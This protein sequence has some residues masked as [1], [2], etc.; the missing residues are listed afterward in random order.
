VNDLLLDLQTINLASTEIEVPLFSDEPK[1]PS[2]FRQKPSTG[3]YLEGEVY[4][5]SLA[6]NVE[7]ARAKALAEFY[8]RLCLYNV[9]RDDEPKPWD[10]DAG[11]IDPTL[12]DPVALPKRAAALRQSAYIWLDAVE[13]R[14][15]GKT[16][17]PAQTVIPGFGAEEER[18]LV[19]VGPGGTALGRVG[20]GGAL[21][22]GLFEVLERF[23]FA[24]S[25][26]QER[27][28]KRIVHLPPK[29]QSIEQVMRRYG[30]EP[31]VCPLQTKY[32]IPCVLVAL[33]DYS[34]VAPAVSLA[35]RAASTYAAAIH[36]ALFE[37]LERRRPARIEETSRTEESTAP[38]VYPWES[39]ETLRE[40]EPLLKE[41]EPIEF[42]SLP[43]TPRTS[44]DLLA[45]LATDDLDV[46]SVDLTLPEV[47]AAGFEATKIVIPG[48]GPM[49]S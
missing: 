24:S 16:K 6:P 43:D 5:L 40:M 13:I 21:Q 7:E 2:Y 45:C 41:A 9:S 48:L 4:G 44:E 23:T 20:D 19:G 10:E 42:S 15:G 26:L 49:P 12:F 17:L 33:T 39:M 3:P 34:G 36:T 11:W 30:L 8:E 37:A 25:S 1:Y 18:I 46:F 32:S 35:M 31:Y 28:Q 22:R 27:I 47:A 29:F 38:R 14:T